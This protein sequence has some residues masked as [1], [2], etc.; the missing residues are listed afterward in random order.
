MS[1]LAASEKLK[2]FVS[3]SRK[4]SSNFAE[5]LVAGLQLAGFAPFLDRHDIVPSEDWESR[6]A[7]LIQ[8]ADTV[9]FV[10]SPEA[11]KSERCGWEVNTTVTLSKRLLPVVF[12]TVSDV[13]IPDHLRRV[14]FVRFDTGASMM[15]P[16]LELAEVLHQDISWIREHTRMGELATRWESRE[17]PDALLIRGG[18]IEEAKKWL[19]HRPK[20]ALEP[21]EL[22]RAFIQESERK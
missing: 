12:K 2:I 19:A 18:E 9:V 14:Q 13:D 5:D 1:E 4:D 17:R 7:D 22:I 3:Y 15:Q 20:N 8:Q 21:S 10:I 11:I 6:L 16:L